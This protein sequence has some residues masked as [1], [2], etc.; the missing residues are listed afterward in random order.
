MTLDER[1]ARPSPPRCCAKVRK[2]RAGYMKQTGVITKMDVCYRAAILLPRICSPAGL[3]RAE[4]PAVLTIS[5]C[6]VVRHGRRRP[7]QQSHQQGQSQR[8][9]CQKEKALLTQI[10]ESPREDDG[11][12]SSH[13]VG[14][15]D[16]A[17]PP[18][19]PSHDESSRRLG[20]NG[21]G[22]RAYWSAREEADWAFTGWPELT[23]VRR[24]R[25]IIPIVKSEARNLLVRDV[26]MVPVDI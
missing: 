5:A 26:L 6:R 18:I 1:P 12:Q 4:G 17:G 22:N 13:H 3:P 11:S 23:T 10:Q 7:E 8:N 21:D 19:V 9:P 24:T 16:Q 15:K 20:R 25:S 2:H 14:Q